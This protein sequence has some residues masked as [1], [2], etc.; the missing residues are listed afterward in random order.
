[1]TLVC[2]KSRY[3]RYTD[4]QG[5]IYVTGQS[6]YYAYDGVHRVSGL[7]REPVVSVSSVRVFCP[8]NSQREGQSLPRH[9]R[10][11]LSQWDVE[12]SVGFFTETT[13]SLL[14]PETRRYPSYICMYL[15]VKDNIQ[16]M[17]K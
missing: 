3:A 6:V 9:D 4:L 8:R 17:T 2:A 15:R 13:G 10:D 1:M 12:I 7:R 14:N 16:Y 5:H 11:H